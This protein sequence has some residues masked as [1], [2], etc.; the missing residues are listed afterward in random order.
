MTVFNAWGYKNYNGVHWYPRICVYD[1]KFGWTR[2][3]HLG[4]EFYGN[5][6]CFDVE[7]E[8]SSDFIVEAT[9]Y[10]T[11]RKEVLP[12]ELRKKLDIKNFKDKTWN[13]TPSI[14]TP[15]NEKERKIWKFHAENV[16]DFAFTADPTY[17]I[18]EAW[19]EDKVC[20]SLVQEPHA[21][22]WQNAADFG[23][24]CLK[25][26]SEDFGRYVYHKVIVADA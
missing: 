11:N 10:L 8:F 17:R 9:G 18:G 4:K 26:F 6:G 3:Q 25:V 2:D 15:Y 20:Y 14:I 1:A 7:L 19:W 13:S 22:K 23:A 16:H 5:F 24:K 21:S 12:E